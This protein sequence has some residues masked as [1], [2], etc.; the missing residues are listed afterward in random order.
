MIR[1]NQ[2]DM[3]LGTCKLRSSGRFLCR[4]QGNI[5]HWLVVFARLGRQA[6]D[7]EHWEWMGKHD[8]SRVVSEI[9]VACYCID[10]LQ[11]WKSPSATL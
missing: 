1:Y 5:Q 11:G 6:L 9:G 10:A 7:W 2:G 8:N 4:L 3:N